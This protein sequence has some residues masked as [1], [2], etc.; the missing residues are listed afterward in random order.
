MDTVSIA[1][2]I[3][4][5]L[6]QQIRIMQKIY[7]YQ[8]TLSVGVFDRSWE[9]V[10]QCV[11]KSTEASRT[12]LQL[13]K[14]NFALLQQLNPHNQDTSDFYGYTAGLPVEVKQKLN[15]LYQQLQRCVR[16]SKIE[17]DTLNAYTEHTQ[18]LISSLVQAVGED[19]K[20][21]FYTK[22]GA[23]TSANFTRLVIDTVS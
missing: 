7:G 8:K 4:E 18:F 14:Q 22:T 20:T 15:Q 1:Q 2:R 11:V 10:E 16:L 9:K 17:N 3:E 23:A 5:T 21:S 6:L 13:D 19:K 12:F